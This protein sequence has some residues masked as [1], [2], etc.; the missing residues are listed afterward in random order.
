MPTLVIGYSVFTGLGAGGGAG[1]VLTVGMSTLSK[2]EVVDPPLSWAES[3]RKHAL[4]DY[5]TAIHGGLLHYD[6]PDLLTPVF[7]GS[8][9][10][11]IV[12]RRAL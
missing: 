6:W 11:R 12:R 5:A 9:F 8:H 4:Y 1:V 2:V 3:V 7:S 10:T